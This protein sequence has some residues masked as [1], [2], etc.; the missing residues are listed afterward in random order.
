MKER[1]GKSGTVKKCSFELIYFTSLPCHVASKDAELPLAT[2]D[3]DLLLPPRV[4][5]SVLF[6][7]EK[8]DLVF[9]L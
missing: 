9:L 3:C 2:R 1:Q 5:S 7:R 8:S 6:F 4:R